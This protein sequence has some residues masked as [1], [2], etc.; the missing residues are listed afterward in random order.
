MYVISKILRPLYL[1]AAF[2]LMDNLL[3]RDSAYIKQTSNQDQFVCP[4]C[5][6]RYKSRS[7]LYNHTHYECGKEKRFACP[8][9]NYRFNY[10]QT[11][12]RH[13]FHRHVKPKGTPGLFRC[14]HCGKRY[15]R[16]DALTKH[17]KE[18]IYLIW[19]LYNLLV[20]EPD[21]LF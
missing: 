18:C 2:F 1:S 14:S 4:K 13:I 7:S 5:F 9:C 6:K 8:H 15:Q 3:H 19:A 12:K 20:N 16:Q 21:A 11:L 10:N 17:Y